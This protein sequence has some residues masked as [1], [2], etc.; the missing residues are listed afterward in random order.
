M[1]R[2][3]YTASDGQQ[4]S[5]VE[6]ENMIVVRTKKGIPLTKSI[7]SAETKKIANKFYQ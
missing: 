4:Y 1:K 3:S 2:L 5:L 7:L 6:S